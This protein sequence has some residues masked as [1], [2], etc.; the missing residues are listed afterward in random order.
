MGEDVTKA[1]LD[2]LNNSAPMENWNKTIITLI[3]KVTNPLMVKEFRLISLCNICY[4]IIARA[5]TNRLR[6]WMPTII[7]ETQCAFIPGRLINIILGFE[8]IHWMRNIKNGKFGYAA[9]KLDM[10]KAYD[11][12]E[13]KFLEVIMNKMGFSES[14]VQLV[15]RC[16]SSVS[17]SFDI[18][19][20]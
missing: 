14:W 20:L 6:S 2:E 9:L 4:K 1:I 12:V 3:P 10:S 8:A 19:T 16:V 7:D 18:Y 11:R 15:M 17:Y 13:W 5:M